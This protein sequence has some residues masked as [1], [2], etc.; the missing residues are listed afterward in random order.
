MITQKRYAIEIALT[1]LKFFGKNVAYKTVLVLGFNE[2]ELYKQI[3]LRYI[4]S[5]KKE[6]YSNDKIET[7]LNE[8]IFG[9]DTETLKLR[10]LKNYLNEILKLSG[11]KEID[12]DNI[13]NLKLFKNDFDYIFVLSNESDFYFSLNTL[14]EYYYDKTKLCFISTNEDLINSTVNRF[15]GNIL[16][17]NVLKT[18][19]NIDKKYYV[20]ILD[21]DKKDFSM[22]FKKYS[23]SDRMLTK[24]FDTRNFNFKKHELI[25]L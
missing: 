22:F 10:D 5:M 23:F 24:K 2:K 4:D 7:I 1:N 14:N 6:N 17:Y 21:F 18:I 8:N 3:V 19:I 12:W 25:N 15:K 16:K 9:Y 20:C 11:L 13:E